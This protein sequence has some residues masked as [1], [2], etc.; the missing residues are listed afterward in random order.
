MK[1]SKLTCGCYL[2][3]L[4]INLFLGA[5]SVNFLLGL[6]GKHIAFI[7]ALLIGIVGGECTIPLAIIVWL[8]KAAGVF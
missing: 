7:Y 2:L 8:L 1:Q 6:I 3:I 5:W 4:T